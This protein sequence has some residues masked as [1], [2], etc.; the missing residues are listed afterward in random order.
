MREISK[1]LRLEMKNVK[2]SIMPKKWWAKKNLIIK[3]SLKSNELRMTLQHLYGGRANT[4]ERLD[5]QRD[6]SEYSWYICLLIILVE[7]LLFFTY[8]FFKRYGFLN[9][10]LMS[11]KDKKSLRLV[12]VHPQQIWRDLKHCLH[13]ECEMA[14]Y[15]VKWIARNGRQT[16]KQKRP[17]KTCSTTIMA[18][19]VM[20]YDRL[21]VI[22]ANTDITR[23][24]ARI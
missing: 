24:R 13:N 18:I 1:T 22:V 16:E 6:P 20:N 19:M 8:S 2:K 15:A 7:N 5:G 10:K 23:A 11:E 12:T 17:V 9:H 4:N 3:V 21:T 14:V